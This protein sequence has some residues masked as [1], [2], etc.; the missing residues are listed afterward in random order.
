MRIKA[1]ILLLSAAEIR[2]DML[3]STKPVGFFFFLRTLEFLAPAARKARKLRRQ[4]SQIVLQ[5]IRLLAQLESK[6]ETV[7]FIFL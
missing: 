2:T 6:K 5:V 3:R 1:K 7:R 4:N